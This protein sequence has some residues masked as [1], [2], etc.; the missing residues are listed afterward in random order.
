MQIRRFRTFDA[1]QIARLFHDT[2]REINLDDYS[3]EQVRAWAPDNLYFRDWAEICSNRLTFVADDDGVIAG[4]A[5]L[6][7]DGHIDCFYCHKDYQRMGAGRRLYRALERK[8]V[9]LGLSN[10]YTE[11]S[12]TAK[13]FFQSRGFTVIREQLVEIRG[14]RLTHFLMEKTL[15][16]PLVLNRVGYWN[17]REDD[18]TYIEAG[19][20]TGWWDP[21]IKPR[22]VRYL[23]SGRVAFEYLGYSWCRFNCGIPDERMGTRDL[24]DGRWIWPEGLSHYVKEHD[25]RQPEPFIETMERNGWK[26]PDM[27]PT[28]Y[29]IQ[30]RDDSW[31]D[32][33]R[34]NKGLMD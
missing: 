17:E 6:E 25:V 29:D 28:D 22:V 34:R 18:E 15:K 27:D 24:T 23:D 12:I 19:A 11:A 20:I 30:I 14:Q 2:V 8:A 3:Q 4:F 7:E 31:L 5:E 21:D 32:F 33:C 10:L 13:P 1:D 26:V 16:E 9:E